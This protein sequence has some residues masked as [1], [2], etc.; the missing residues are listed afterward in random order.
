M[1][2]CVCVCVLD[3]AIVWNWKEYKGY[4]RMGSDGLLHPVPG[5]P[6]SLR[7]ASNIFRF[8]VFSLFEVRCHDKALNQSPCM[9]VCVR[10]DELSLQAEVETP[11]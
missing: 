10:S 9:C 1:H 5:V 3:L 7:A 6:G 11:R 4:C 8:C 2:M